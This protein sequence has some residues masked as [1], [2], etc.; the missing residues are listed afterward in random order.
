MAQPEHAAAA[1]QVRQRPVHRRGCSPLLPPSSAWS[2]R[3][4]LLVLSSTFSYFLPL[5]TGASAPGGA[6]GG[7]R[8]GKHTPA[9]IA[10][11]SRRDRAEIAPRSRRD[12]ADG[13]AQAIEHAHARAVAEGERSAV[14]AEVARIEPT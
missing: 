1:E 14:I 8:A 6:R 3:P 5:S 10:P 12:H 13:L 9:V 4:P 11:R 7:A 2:R